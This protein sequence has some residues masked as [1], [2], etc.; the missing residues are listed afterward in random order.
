MVTPVLVKPRTRRLKKT[1]LY[2]QAHQAIRSMI[3]NGDLPLGQP[4]GEAAIADHLG[5][6]RT[7][8]RE[9]FKSL[10]TEGLLVTHP[11]GAI[12]VF[13]PSVEDVAEVYIARAILEG[14][15]ARLLL[16]APRPEI[17][18]RL[19]Q[20]AKL[21][22]EAA[23]KGDMRTAIK[24]NAEFHELIVKG[25]RNTRIGDLL[26]TLA[27]VIQRYSRLSAHFADQMLESSTE[28]MPIVEAI[29]EGQPARVEEVARDHI[30]RAG[31]RTVEAIEHLDQVTL[32]P[33]SP[34][35]VLMAPYRKGPA[36]VEMKVGAGGQG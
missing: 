7:P 22:G 36:V 26:D 18:R 34:S 11:S 20:H 16:I 17:F 5:V 32:D 12:T 29:L 21:C 3:L 2:E 23:A 30:I 27:P 15:A 8:V 4:V 14:F 28:H 13:A 1:P 19:E 33:E 9:A 6:S 24:Q 25:S 10:I 35:A 31:T